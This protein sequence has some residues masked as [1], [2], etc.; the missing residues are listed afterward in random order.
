MA[1]I[2]F[3]G[4][5]AVVKDSETQTN[6]VRRQFDYKLN[7]KNAKSKLLKAA[8][9]I[10]FEIVKNTGSMN[11][12]FNVGSWNNIVLPSIRYWN[13]VKG[14]QTCKVGGSTVRIA[15][16]KTGM[17][18][19]G[20]HVDTQI[21][22]FI[23]RDKVTCH[24][25]NTTLLILVNGH[26]HK[27][28]VEEFLVPY[29][30]AKIKINE[31][32]IK[33]F[34]EQAL[35]SLGGKMVKRNSVRYK[36]GSVFPC[37]RC[38]FATKTLDALGKHIRSEHGL[39]STG[40]SQSIISPRHSTC[41]NSVNEG[42]SKDI[43][44]K[45]PSNVLPMIEHITENLKYTCLECDYKT[46]TK[47]NMK[48]HVKSIHEPETK[49]IQIIC[50][51]CKHNFVQ[52]E[53]FN[54]HVKQHEVKVVSNTPLNQDNI[55]IEDLLHEQ[56]FDDTKHQPTL[57]EHSIAEEKSIIEEEKDNQYQCEEC[58][59]LFTGRLDLNR[60]KDMGHKNDSCINDP[61]SCR[62]QIEGLQDKQPIKDQ[63]C[64]VCQICNLE[65]KNL[66]MLK[67]HIENIHEKAN[68][69]HDDN[70]KI[71]I[72]RT[73]LCTK[74]DLCEFR[75]NKS[76][77]N[78]HSN[79]KHGTMFACI[80]CGNVFFDKI[81][82]KNHIQSVH[83]TSEPFPCELCGLVLADF[84]L[85][86]EHQRNFHEVEAV[87]C[88]YCEYAVKN[89]EALEEHMIEHHEQIVILHTMATQVVDLHEQQQRNES[90]Q[91]EV[92]DLLRNFSK[93]FDKIEKE[94]V[95]S[96]KLNLKMDKKKTL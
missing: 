49:D 32:E 83:T 5:D 82:L 41:N 55:S 77:M 69:K 80:E 30:E 17:E 59:L 95:E 91:T 33:I 3:N 92:L 66:E 24:F 42:I 43:N 31:E 61:V 47:E 62:S 52:E 57:E 10:P 56:L 16:V 6:L 23:D 54:I 25:Y 53:D 18:T 39:N 44:D 38:V 35:E 71:Q 64:V 72:Q 58:G 40:D 21:V 13:Q 79:N 94:L 22:F 45:T 65:S 46:K 86:Q 48:K 20:K 60:H 11:L 51:I 63:T 67:I 96:R 1:L 88:R 89:K 85:L 4:I 90:F 81:V 27:S 28:L 36:G 93:R 14:E 68:I 84:S 87:N 29:L 73:E 19:G 50:G 26:G 12:V 2:E 76:E 34:N 15:S 37:N 78:K 7:D 70:E 9:R 74:C 75:G 8:K